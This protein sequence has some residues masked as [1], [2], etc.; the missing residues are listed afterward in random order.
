MLSCILFCVPC[1]LILPGF[2]HNRENAATSF[3]LSFLT[4]LSQTRNNSGETLENY[5]FTRLL[6]NPAV[7]DALEVHQDISSITKAQAVDFPSLSREIQKISDGIQMA[8]FL[9]AEETNEKTL[10]K[11]DA[12]LRE[13]RLQLNATQLLFA[14]SQK[15]FFELCIFFGEDTK[16]TPASIFGTLQALMAKITAAKEGVRK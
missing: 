7:A 11:L 2:T 3:K 14:E 10:T 15:A 6:Q 16:S 12:Y 13:A 1:F 9:K 5:V 8:S 4:K